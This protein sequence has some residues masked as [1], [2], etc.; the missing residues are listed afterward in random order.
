MAPGL[1]VE[2]FIANRRDSKLF[3]PVKEC[4]LWE[5]RS[6]VAEVSLSVYDQLDSQ[7]SMTEVNEENT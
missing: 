2:A 4:F 5:D 3:I 7:S 1:W 6:I